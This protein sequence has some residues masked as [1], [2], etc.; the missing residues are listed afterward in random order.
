MDSRL[1]HS[2]R[3]EMGLA[4][5]IGSNYVQRHESGRFVAWLSTAVENTGRALS[6]LVSECSRMARE[7]VGEMELLLCKS[8]AVGRHALKNMEYESLASRLLARLSEGYPL[9]EDIRFASRCLSLTAD[10]LQGMA[11]RYFENDPWFISV[12]GG[13]CGPLER[14]GQP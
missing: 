12:A 6:A 10:D 13:D 7:P 1:G 11:L 2:L 9:D 8:S 5:A 4:Y 3:D 14:P